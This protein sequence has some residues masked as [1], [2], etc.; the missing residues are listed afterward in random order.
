VLGAKAGRERYT[1]IESKFHE[2]AGMP[3]VKNATA[4]AK[5]TAVDL[6]D[7]AKASVNEKVKSASKEPVIDLSSGSSGAVTGSTS[8]MAGAAPS[9]SAPDRTRP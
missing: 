5:Q 3:A 9:G 4:S 2:V 1:Q 6:A 8:P 7:T